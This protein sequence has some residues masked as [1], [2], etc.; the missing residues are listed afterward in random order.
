M[1]LILKKKKKAT[2]NIQQMGEVS[3]FQASIRPLDTL[4]KA[5]VGGGSRREVFWYKRF[6]L[7][8][9]YL[10]ITIHR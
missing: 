9:N 6:S 8:E 4:R 5:P 10:G 7:V 2:V 1:I 3:E